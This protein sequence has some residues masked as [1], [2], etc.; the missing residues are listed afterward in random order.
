M[1]SEGLSVSSDGAVKVFESV[2]ADACPVQEAK[3]PHQENGPQRA[4]CVPPPKG[5]SDSVPERHSSTRLLKPPA[6]FDIFHQRDLRETTK[7]FEYVAADK[8][9]LV[10][11]RDARQARPAIHEG[12]DD[13]AA[14]RGIVESDV[15]PSAYSG[16][17]GQGRFDDPS[18]LRRQL[19]VGMQEQEN[20]TLAGCC[21]FVH[22]AC[23]PSWRRDHAGIGR[24]GAKFLSEADGAVGAPSVDDDDFGEGGR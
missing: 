9:S 3:G 14:N 21:A 15:E 1:K 8:E 7:E 4:L 24:A 2:R 20:F 6:E 12:T 16:V 18:G 5:G 11:G 22:L 13:S 10:A 19:C 17:L 23:T